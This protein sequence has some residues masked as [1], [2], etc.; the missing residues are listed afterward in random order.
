MRFILVTISVLNF[1]QGKKRKQT[2]LFSGMNE[3]ELSRDTLSEKRRLAENGVV[4]LLIRNSK[5]RRDVLDIQTMGINQ[6]D[7]NEKAQLKNY[8]LQLDFKGK[9]FDQ[10]LRALINRFFK[11][12]A[13]QTPKLLYHLV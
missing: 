9:N 13:A 3:I 7:D 10:D 12:L 5:G 11:E 1:F 2:I 6:I 4:S 8:I